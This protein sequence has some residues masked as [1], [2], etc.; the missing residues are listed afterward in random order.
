MKRYRTMTPHCLAAILML[1]ACSGSVPNRPPAGEAAGSDE[2]GGASGTE[3]H[4]D[5]GV[6]AAL[7]VGHRLTIESTILGEVR[8]ASVALPTGYDNS[9]TAYPVLY[10]L[11]GEWNF[12]LAAGLVDHLSRWSR[13]PESIVVAIHN[14]N[15]TRD[16]TPSEDADFYGSG[17]AAVFLRFLVEDLVPRVEATYRTNGFRILVGH[18]FGGLFSI[19]ALT[20]RPAVFDAIVSVAPSLWLSDDWMFGRLDALVSDHPDLKGFLYVTI[21]EGEDP[22]TR[23]ANQRF[24]DWLQANAPA[25][26]EWHYRVNEKE[27]HF[28]NLPV[29]LQQGLQALYPVWGA[30]EELYAR[31]KRE[32]PPGAGRWLA[33][34][35]ERLGPRFVLTEFEILQTGYRFIEE[36]ESRAAEAVFDVLVEEFPGSGQPWAGKAAAREAEGRLEAA[37]DAF[38]RALQIGEE[39]GEPDR[40]LHEYGVGLE[41]VTAR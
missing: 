11:D 15:R 23:R 26:L 16:L 5:S 19:F 3:S 37:A 18:S 40:F 6:R 33:E 35:R 27:N 22:R 2:P 41:R 4:Q 32:G 1:G 36:G 25:T 30:E 29:S 10:V 9:E 24:Q 13:I 39:H 28:S 7:E 17:A 8:T 20:E 14:T 31:T 12:L 21:G 34:R 38:R